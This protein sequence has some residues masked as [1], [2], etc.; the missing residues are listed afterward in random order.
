M[1]PFSWPV[2]IFLAC[3]PLS[4]FASEDL[5]Q[6]SLKNCAGLGVPHFQKNLA[7]FKNVL[8]DGKNWEAAL[9]AHK[10]ELDRLVNVSCPAYLRDPNGHTNLKIFTAEYARVASTALNLK[11]QSNAVE[12][13]LGEEF[14]EAKKYLWEFNALFEGAPCGKSLTRIREH[15]AAE[16]KH[17]ETQFGL[18]KTKCPVLAEAANANVSPAEGVRAE[19]SA[20]RSAPVKKGGKPAAGS[21]STI[22]GVKP[23]PSLSE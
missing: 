13:F 7:K 22:T 3:L 2:V 5:W 20:G 18:L 12:A 10:L 1:K 21:S 16:N 8:G 9:P 11:S 4:S 19:K 6:S 14:R 17:T 23:D 15:I